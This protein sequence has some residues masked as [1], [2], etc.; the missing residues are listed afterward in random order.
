MKSRDPRQ[1]AKKLKLHRHIARTLTVEQLEQ[2][3][4]GQS[5]FAQTT[6]TVRVSQDPDGQS[7]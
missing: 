6:T 1:P 7:G 2:V 3:V 5:L 4:G